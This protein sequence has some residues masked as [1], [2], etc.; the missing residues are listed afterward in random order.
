VLLP[1][2]DAQLWG[3]RRRGVDRLHIRQYRR[4]H[5]ADLL[6][7]SRA[8]PSTT[9]GLLFHIAEHATRHAG[10]ADDGEVMGAGVSA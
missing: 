3:G 1:C 5:R 9:I 6:G 10:R 7:R 2:P 8:L 4:Q